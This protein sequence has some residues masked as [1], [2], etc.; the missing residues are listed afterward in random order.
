MRSASLEPARLPVKQHDS[1]MMSS[2]K[3]VLTKRDEVEGDSHR[4]SISYW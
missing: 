3:I 1:L 2:S 4:K